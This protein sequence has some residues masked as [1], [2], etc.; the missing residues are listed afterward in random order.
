MI[1]RPTGRDLERDELRDFV[2]RLSQRP[3]LWREYVR[4]DDVARNYEQLIRDQYLTVWVNCWSVDHDT[5]FHDHDQSS[6][7]VTVVEGL[8]RED[9]LRLG[10]DPVTATF[11]PGEVFTFDGSDIHR[12]LHGGGPPAVTLHAYSPPLWRMGAYT[13]DDD[14][15]LK[16]QSISYAE[17]LRPLP[18]GHSHS[19][20]D[21]A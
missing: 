7:A 9:R 12:V 17:E 13:T 16:R 11:K 10:G 18:M 1:D 3:E 21:A 19:A 20:A 4:H 5:G 2:L 8:V 14:G 6:G 15:S